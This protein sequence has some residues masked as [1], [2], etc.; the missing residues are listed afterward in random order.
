MNLDRVVDISDPIRLLGYLFGELEAG[1][2]DAA[3]A[4]NNELLEVTDAIAILN[5]LFK[6][7]AAPPE[8]FPAIGLD[9][10]AEGPLDCQEGFDPFENP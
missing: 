9:E 5:F 8:P 4:D 2:L 10:D 7:G 3:D 6:E 1:C